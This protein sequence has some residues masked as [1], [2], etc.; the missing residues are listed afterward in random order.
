VLIFNYLQNCIL[1]GHKT[2]KAVKAAEKVAKA[3]AKIAKAAEK[4]KE[5]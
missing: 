2:G 1:R 5:N 3:E 4:S